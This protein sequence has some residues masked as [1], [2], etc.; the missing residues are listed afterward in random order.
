MLERY[1]VRPQT[2]D[3]IR[4]LWLGPALTR[5]AEWITERCAAKDTGQRSLQALI[6]FS[7]FAQAR[8][9]TAWED[10]PAHLQPFVDDWV[11][12]RGVCDLAG[13]CGPKLTALLAI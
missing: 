2:A 13:Q 8:G 6:H 5:Y 3:R 11:R 1:F 7:D 10:L 4:G 12:R 9:A